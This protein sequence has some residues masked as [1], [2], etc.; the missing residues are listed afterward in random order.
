MLS[1]SSLSLTVLSDIPNCEWILK[2][3]D[4]LT[5]FCRFHYCYLLPIPPPW[6]VALLFSLFTFI[7]PPWTVVLYFLL[8]KFIPPSW[9]VAL[10]L[11]AIYFPRKPPSW[12]VVLFLFFIYFP[13][14]PPSWSVAFSFS[15][16]SLSFLVLVLIP[17]SGSARLEI[18]ILFS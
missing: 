15:T 1:R 13:R 11:S 7:P 2:T 8:F 5:I 9:T 14:I 16:F 4:L 6:S 17:H 10:L 12:S 3:L 18:L